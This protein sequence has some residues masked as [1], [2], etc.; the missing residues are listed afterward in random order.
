[1]LRHLLTVGVWLSGLN[2][3][4]HAAPGPPGAAAGRVDLQS[5]V[6]IAN[7]C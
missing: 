2:R 1:M 5:T 4:S 6:S 7:F 3:E